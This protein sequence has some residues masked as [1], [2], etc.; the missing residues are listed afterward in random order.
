ML[1]LGDDGQ[2]PPVKNGAFQSLQPNPLTTCLATIRGFQIFR[3]LIQ[4]VRV[5]D[6]NLRQDE[7]ESS[8]HQI[9]DGLYFGNMTK[10]ALQ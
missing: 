3:N 9:L 5:L 4:N 7:T 2:L 6:Q 10:Q 1:L 8:F